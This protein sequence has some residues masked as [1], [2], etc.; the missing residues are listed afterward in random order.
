MGIQLAS[1][2]Y[3]I[4]TN[5]PKPISVIYLPLTTGGAFMDQSTC[6]HPYLVSW[7]P[8]SSLY[9]CVLTKR[10]LISNVKQLTIV[11]N[12][13]HKLYLQQTFAWTQ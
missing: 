11:T 12:S 9:L 4:Q 10:H 7:I 5:K 8:S 6:K 1:S 13:L 2:K 3:L